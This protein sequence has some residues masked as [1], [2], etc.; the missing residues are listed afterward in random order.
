MEA[1]NVTLS[2]GR[3]GTELESDLA[4]NDTLAESG[5]AG[6]TNVLEGVLNTRNQVGNELGDGSTVENGSRDTL[7]DKESVA[8]GEVAGGTGVGGLGVV[9]VGR[10]NT[11]LLVLHGVDRTHTSV[12]LDELTLT[13]DKGLTGR[14]GGT[15]KETSHHDS[16]GTESKTLDNV[17]NVLDTTVSNAG[18]T[19]AG[20][21][22]GNAVDGSSLRTTDGHDLLG[23]TG[24]ARA[25]TNSETVNTSSD[26]AGGLLTGDN[27]ATNDIETRVGLLDV[28]DHLNLVHGV[29]LRRVK[30]DNVETSVNELLQTSLVVGAGTDGSSGDQL[31]GL[32]ELGGEGVV[33]VLHQIGA[34][35]ERDEVAVV[36]NDGEL[37]LLGS[38]KDG[39][40]LGE[41]N[42]ALG[43]DELGGHDL[44]DRVV[45]VVVEL[46][47]T[48]GDDTEKLGAKLAGLCETMLVVLSQKRAQTEKRIVCIF[49][50]FQNVSPQQIDLNAVERKLLYL[51]S[52]PQGGREKKGS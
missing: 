39:V 32:G 9:G 16:A 5:Q 41:L 46:N 37:A 50:R 1:V 27:V 15:G 38:L 35:D 3:D 31:L 28:L 22:R 13:R 30:D 25:H 24:R 40:G 42:T 2:L 45:Q 47:I 6:D 36:V 51:L 10:S 18:N 33:Q 11:S 19:E 8:L 17:A 49:F 43:S 34:R 20:S 23:D 4:V 26:K 52:H 48:R 14:L 29:T 12:G 7:G 21:E 44:A